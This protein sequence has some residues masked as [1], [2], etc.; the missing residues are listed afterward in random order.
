MRNF[1]IHTLRNG[2][3]FF[4]GSFHTD[5]DGCIIPFKSWVKIV[6][7]LFNNSLVVRSNPEFGCALFLQTA[8][9]VRCTSGQLT[10]QNLRLLHYFILI[11][12]WTSVY[13]AYICR[14]ANTV[15]NAV[16]RGT[17]K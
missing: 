3:D 17:V 15:S 12:R 6:S 8:I 5:V 7:T 11:C 9:I 16:K 10:W 14:K 2:Y 1:A 4:R 13:L